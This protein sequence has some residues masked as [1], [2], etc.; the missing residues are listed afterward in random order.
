MKIRIL[1]VDD[2]RLMRDG[3]KTILEIEEDMQVTGTASN[4]CEAAK[5]C[6]EDPP[7][8]VL[9]DI[10][11]PLMDGIEATHRIIED[12]PEVRVISLTTFDDD[13]LI[14]GALKAGARTYVLKDLPS[15]RLMEVIRA[16]ARGDVLLQPEI[17][18]RLID[19][20]QSSPVR[21]TNRVPGGGEGLTSRER[22]VLALMA[23]GHTN[24]E[25]ASDLFLSTGTVKNYISSI[26]SKLGVNDRT[27]AVLLAMKHRLV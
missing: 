20:A 18:A 4:G 25:I 17:A 13:E 6:R 16:T 3:L 7:D 5:L 24:Q 11:M 8:V 19:A 27:Q 10:Q 1:I 12:N 9:M 2:Q 22:E 23:A 14:I 26:Y 15:E 21:D